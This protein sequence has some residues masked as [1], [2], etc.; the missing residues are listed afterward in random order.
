MVFME[1][2]ERAASIARESG[3][4]AGLHLNFTTEF[5]APRYSSA[6]LKH[7]R[8]VSRF[9]MCHP[10]AQ[11]IFHPGLAGSFEYLMKS[12]HDEFTRLYGRAPERLDG[13]HHMHLCANVLLQGLLPRSKMVRRNFSFRPGTKPVWNRVYRRLVDRVLA[14]GHRL[15]DYFFSMKPLEP[16]ERLHEI[17]SLAKYSVVEVETH[18]A[19][20]E[21]YIFLT[22]GRLFRHLTEVGIVRPL[23]TLS[24][25]L[26]DKA[27]P[28]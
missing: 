25:P 8:R 24:G 28:W 9:L 13:H 1:D 11:V 21:E 27:A 23:P 15:T 18:P 17:F 2:S 3:I 7:H 14:R 26:G 5:T 4:D 22:G 20:P 10:G 12:Q 16:D 19:V 6:L